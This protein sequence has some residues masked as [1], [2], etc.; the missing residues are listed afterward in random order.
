MKPILHRAAPVKFNNEDFTPLTR[1]VA[2][3]IALM[4]ALGFL[5]AY[6]STPGG[7]S[8]E[9]AFF[10]LGYLVLGTLV[11]MIVSVAVRLYLRVSP[12][13]TQRSDLG[14]NP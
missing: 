13:H 3:A 2:W 14:E 10:G 6:S 8:L 5:V 1:A 11:V 7:L 9:R 4:A 12:D